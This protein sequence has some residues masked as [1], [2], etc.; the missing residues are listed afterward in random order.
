MKRI[1][2]ALALISTS[3]FAGTEFNTIKVQ[4]GTV[5]RCKVKYDL[6]RNK[7]GV[8]TAEATSVK[9]EDETLTFEVDLKFLAC[10]KENDTF[11]FF[12]KS[13]Y[14]KLEWPTSSGE[15]VVVA[16]AKEVSLKAYKDSVYKILTDQVLDREEKQ[17][18][19]ITVALKD[20][21]NNA[22]GVTGKGSF[23]LW[24]SKKMNYTVESQGVEF[25]KIVH[26][27]SYRIH[28]EVKETV[29]GLKASLL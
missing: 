2:L 20:V 17:T 8:Y 15:S 22:E 3:V 29:E 21:L 12:Y 7:E 19:T 23:D 27:G 1:M 16:Q 13:P 6:H 10:T 25:N 9:L 18:R 11:K 26:Y 14:S 24:I 5:A 28:F 4:D